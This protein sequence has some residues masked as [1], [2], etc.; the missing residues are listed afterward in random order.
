LQILIF[1]DVFANMDYRI[2]NG[3]LRKLIEI[4][5]VNNLLRIFSLIQCLILAI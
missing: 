1:L 5:F 4:L 2:K 3:L